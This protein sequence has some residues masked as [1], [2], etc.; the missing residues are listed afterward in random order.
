MKFCIATASI[1]L[2]IALTTA[3][4]LPSRYSLQRRGNQFVTGPCNIDSDCQ[5][6]CCA[7]NT[8]KCAGPGIAQTRD[9]G[10]GHGNKVPNCNVAAALKLG[11]CVAGAVNDDLSNPDIQSAAA[12]VAKLDGFKFTPITKGSG[13]AA[14]AT[15]TKPSKTSTS[16]STA[17]GGASADKTISALAAGQS[18]LGF[19]TA[20]CA[21]DS[22][23]QQGCCSF[24]AGTCVGPAIAQ[25][26]AQ[27]GGCG[28][29]APKP[30]CDV[31][32]ALNLSECV[33][34]AVNGDLTSHSIQ[35]A[36][37]F[38]SILD[39]LPFSPAA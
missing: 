19:V 14:T 1:A 23:C 28:F 29:G 35:A 27:D 33:A 4:E 7:F 17:T 32:K 11:D 18:S 36:A 15:A 3:H 20:T 5:Q 10:C 37:A 39:K 31:A 8:G 24:K 13:N 21:A 12:F 26:R 38:V 6:G 22:D 16:K 9:G 30:N 2:Y 25:E 34:G